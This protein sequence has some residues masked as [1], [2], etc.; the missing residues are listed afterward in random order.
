MKQNSCEYVD[1]YAYGFTT[2]LMEKAGF[3]ERMEEDE[4]IIPNY[5]EPFEQ[6]NIELWMMR[7]EVDGLILMRGDGDQDRPC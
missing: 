5:F 1:I 4:N 3:C 6:R 2:E 7:P